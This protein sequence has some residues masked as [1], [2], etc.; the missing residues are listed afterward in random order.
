MDKQIIDK[1]LPSCSPVVGPDDFFHTPIK[2]IKEVG[3]VAKTQCQ[4][5]QNPNFNFGSNLGSP[6][7]N[8]TFL[9]GA[10][11]Q[12]PNITTLVAGTNSRTWL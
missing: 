11:L 7:A 10:N 4:V 8:F 9:E 3:R 1:Y 2:W 5:P 12:L 6:E